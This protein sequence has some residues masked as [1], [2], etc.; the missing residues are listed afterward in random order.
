MLTTCSGPPHPDT[1]LIWRRL[2]LPGHEFVRL[3]REGSGW[4]LEGCAVFLH[5]N[6]AVR[7]E[8]RIGCNARWQTR[9]AAVWGRIGARTVRIHLL[10]GPGGRWRFNGEDQPQVQG[11][12]DVD[13][14]FSPSTNLLPVRRLDLGIGQSAPVRAA[15]L[16]FPALALEPLE[17]TY[18]RTGPNR[19]RYESAGGA[20]TAGLVMDAHGLV[21]D[22]PGL[23]RAESADGISP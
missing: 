15:W 22:Y 9:F 18:Q 5:G 20:F 8:Y 2:D 21:L 23:W 17:Q 1:T 13:L 4:V 12:E 6:D 10:R 7:L 3:G 14:G 19:F 16:T 11:C